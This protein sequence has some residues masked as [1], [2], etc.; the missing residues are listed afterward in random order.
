MKLAYP[1]T[2]SCLDVMASAHLSVALL[3]FCTAELAEGIHFLGPARVASQ[4]AVDWWRKRVLRRFSDVDSDGDGTVTLEEMRVGFGHE[5]AHLGEP[6]LRQM[7]T[8]CAG[9]ASKAESCLREEMERSLA[10]W[11]DS[12]NGREALGR[13]LRDAEGGFDF[14][15]LSDKNDNGP[16]GPSAMPSPPDAFEGVKCSWQGATCITGGGLLGWSLKE[17]CIARSCICEATADTK[18]LAKLGLMG[19]LAVSTAQNFSDPGDEMATPAC[20]GG[21]SATRVV[22][23]LGPKEMNDLDFL[24]ATGVD[25]AAHMALHGLDREEAIHAQTDDTEVAIFKSSEH[26][27]V[28]GGKPG[29]VCMISWQGTRS[30][31]DWK[32][33]LMLKPVPFEYTPPGLGMAAPKGLVWAYASTRERLKRTF[34]QECCSADFVVDKVVVSGHSHG[35]ALAELN[36]IDMVTNWECPRGRDIG[37]KEM[38]VVP[39]APH[40]HMLNLAAVNEVFSCVD[41]ARCLAG[42][43]ATIVSE[44]DNVGD[45]ML[46]PGWNIAPKHPSKVSFLPCPEVHEEADGGNDSTTFALWWCHGLYVYVPAM[47]RDLVGRAGWGSSCG[48][49]CGDPN[50]QVQCNQYANM[51]QEGCSYAPP[52]ILTTPTECSSWLEDEER[53]DCHYDE[54]WELNRYG[55][56][57]P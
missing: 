14:V 3:L 53:C 41:P 22:G 24:E 28:K 46:D 25:V 11:G 13:H 29:K 23:H 42:S 49:I 40:A 56:C 37:A 38:A 31:G 5:P 43:V 35:G 57:A 44:G 1:D 2:E 52:G 10:T 39:I 30:S 45:F 19:A 50:R 51:A 15:D 55:W 18:R 54:C 47:E 33:N 48:G 21:W 12:L 9:G 27:L 26:Q 16:C 8:E 17:L 6:L 4:E 34:E 36:A 20:G 32:T 7:L